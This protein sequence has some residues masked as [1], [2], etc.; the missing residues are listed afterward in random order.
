MSKKAE[1]YT[2]STDAIVLGLRYI[3]KDGAH[4][5]GIPAKSLNPAEVA[6]LSAAQVDACL[7]SS[8][9][10]VIHES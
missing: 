7:K 1:P 2:T 8:L 10:E 4:I 3:G 6:L 9:Y 5:S